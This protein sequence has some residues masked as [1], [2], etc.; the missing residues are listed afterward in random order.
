[1]FSAYLTLHTLIKLLV[2]EN[3]AIPLKIYRLFSVY[4]NYINAITILKLI[5]HFVDIDFLA[6]CLSVQSFSY[7]KNNDFH[8]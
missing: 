6:M 8:L 4:L 2:S 5:G 7:I 1:M 3:Y